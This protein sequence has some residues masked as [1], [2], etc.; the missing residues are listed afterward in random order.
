MSDL[1]RRRERIYRLL[2]GG[3]Q[4]LKLNKSRLWSLVRQV[5][6]ETRQTKPRSNDTGK[7]SENRPRN[8]GAVSND[9]KDNT[10]GK[11]SVRDRQA[12]EGGTHRGSLRGSETQSDPPSEKN[13]IRPGANTTLSAEANRGDRKSPEGRST[14]LSRDVG[15][16]QKP[17]VQQCGTEKTRKERA[18]KHQSQLHGASQTCSQ[19]ETVTVIDDSEIS[20]S[21]SEKDLFQMMKVGT[22]FDI[23]KLKST[24]SFEK[25]FAHRMKSV[26]KYSQR[27]AKFQ[28][29]L[30]KKKSKDVPKSPDKKKKPQKLPEAVEEEE[31]EEEVA[32]EVSPPMVLGKLKEFKFL[33]YKDHI[34]SVSKVEDPLHTDVT[35]DDLFDY[36]LLALQVYISSYCCFLFVGFCESL[37]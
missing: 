23:S 34:P 10:R 17:D 2:E 6:K 26:P 12:R 33:Q 1:Q 9:A 31:K 5:P 3:K 25:M 29:P 7:R 36:L 19:D 16:L 35:A 21:I 37:I 30:T 32:V 14:D 22:H 24:Y 20:D 15:H 11:S 27:L 13:K 18:G 8:P 4:I 28:H